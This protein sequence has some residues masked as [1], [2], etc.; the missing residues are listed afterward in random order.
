MSPRPA[1]AAVVGLRRD[2]AGGWRTAG[3]AALRRHLASDGVRQVDVARKLGTS[4]S[5]LCEVAAGHRLPSL[6]LAVALERL[7]GVRPAAWLADEESV[8]ADD[9][10][11]DSESESGDNQDV[12]GDTAA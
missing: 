9:V 5:T 2:G 7:I 11:S 10:I 8:S 4:P 1:P 3:R 6:P 12:S